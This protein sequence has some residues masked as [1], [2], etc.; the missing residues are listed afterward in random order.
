MIYIC[1]D[2][3]RMKNLSTQKKFFLSTYKMSSEA[4]RLTQERKINVKK[5]SKNKIHAICVNKGGA[6]DLYVI[7][8]KMI[9]LRENSDLRNLCHLV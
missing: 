7:W 6:N 2:F 3:N 5:Y 4:E 9:D 1:S 8:V